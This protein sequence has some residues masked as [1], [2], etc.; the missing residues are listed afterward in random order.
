MNL[1]RYTRSSSADSAPE[2]HT[3]AENTALDLVALDSDERGPSLQAVLRLR[4]LGF[5]PEDKRLNRARRKPGRRIKGLRS[6]L[7]KSATSTNRN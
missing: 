1:F 2:R 7:P 3:R 4:Q 6:W 5:E